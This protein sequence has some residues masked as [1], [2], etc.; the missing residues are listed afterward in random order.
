MP[1]GPHDITEQLEAL[2][3]AH[4]LTYVLCGISRVCSEKAEH[5]RANWQ[6]NLSAR[7]W[8]RDA[9]IVEKAARAVHA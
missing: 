9:A 7:H 5:L 1:N 6:D 2:I 3:D 4:G 8:G